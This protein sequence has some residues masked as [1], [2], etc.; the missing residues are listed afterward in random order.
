MTYNSNRSEP[1]ARTRKTE[2][3][4]NLVI[5]VRRQI[6]EMINKTFTNDNLPAVGEDGEHFVEVVVPVFALAD[7]PTER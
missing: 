1:N 3:N 6:R 2:T 4:K 5:W 7:E